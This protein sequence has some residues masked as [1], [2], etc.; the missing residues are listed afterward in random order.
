[1]KE[2]R[3]S[4][5]RREGGGVSPRGRDLIVGVSIVGVGIAG[6]LSGLLGH[7]TAMSLALIVLFVL[8]PPFVTAL[9]RASASQPTMQGHLRVIYRRTPWFVAVGVVAGVTS[10]INAVAYFGHE[11]GRAVVEVLAGASVLL[12]SI[13]LLL[14]ARQRT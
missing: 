6:I 12:A 7:P 5:I 13:R 9:E 2:G 4:V 14:R 11:P 10:V 8:I 3:S 1:M